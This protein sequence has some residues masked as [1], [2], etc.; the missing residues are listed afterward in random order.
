MLKLAWNA[1]KT[2]VWN[3]G[4]RD[5]TWEILLL[6]VA[7]NFSRNTFPLPRKFSFVWTEFNF[8]LNSKRLSNNILHCVNWT[9]H[10]KEKP[11]F[12]AAIERN[13]RIWRVFE[14]WTHFRLSERE[15]MAEPPV[16]IWEQ[17]VERLLR[18]KDLIPRLEDALG[19]FSRRDRTEVIQPVRT[20]VPLQ[21]HKG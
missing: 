1:I 12:P 3:Y 8:F 6:A 20:A 15:D 18:Y 17:D 19:K 4:G 9:Q 11:N 2:L 10:V 21:K 14:L 16:V 5:G 7:F 13:A